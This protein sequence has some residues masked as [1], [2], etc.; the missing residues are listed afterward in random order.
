MDNQ[1]AKEQRRYLFSMFLEASKYHRKLFYFSA[2]LAGSA[3]L[4]MDIAIP[5]VVAHI[6]SDIAQ[7]QVIDSAGP[8]I[9]F[10]IALGLLELFSL[11]MRRMMVYLEERFDANCRR[12]VVTNAFAKLLEQP[13]Y[14]HQSRFV[15]TTINLISKCSDCFGRTSGITIFVFVPMSVS[16]IGTCVVLATRVPWYLVALLGITIAYT[17]V[18]L[19]LLPKQMKLSADASSISSK[20]YGAMSD[21]VSNIAAVKS[22]SGEN[23][24]F[25]RVYEIGDNWLTVH[26]SFA[27][28]VLIR[29]GILSNGL[30]RALRALSIVFAV[31]AA[32]GDVNNVA[33]IYLS[34]T[35][36]L[37]YLNHLW[38]FGD[39][40][41]ELTMAYGDAAPIVPL[42]QAKPG[43]AD[44][45]NA[46]ELQRVQG[47][48]SLEK[49]SYKYPN[50]N[51][52]V[53]TDLDLKIEPG[54]RVGIVGRSGAGKSTLVKL[55]MRF[56]DPQSGV[57]KIDDIDINDVTQE[58]LRRN[59]SYVAQ[60][61][62]LFHRSIYS[63]ITYGSTE[64]SDDKIEEVLVRSHSKEFI[65]TMPKGLRSVVGERGVNLSG[66]QRQRIAIARA[67]LKNAA[68]LILDE[69]TS[70]L[71]SESEG[72]VQSAFADLMTD[73]TT[74]VIAHRLS[75]LL[76]MDRILV[77]DEG[78]IIEQGSHEDL[79]EIKGIYSDLWSQ[80]AGGFIPAS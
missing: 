41:Y 73:R 20:M 56:I 17:F 43:V 78:R 48:I 35:L 58:S 10:L 40:L 62:M 55:I 68:I 80:Q 31:F 64:I 29:D 46:V 6:L 15:G 71:D 54:E 3:A 23:I 61:P 49:V 60:E 79:L 50:S 2:F 12:A 9:P 37:A 11:L 27:R 57:I 8:Y 52:D 21:A 44:R 72:Y 76:K 51:A 34:A 33:I 42:L 75:T 32:V 70:A 13:A 67:M 45:K 7:K 77:F 26:K 66:G 30:V 39:A 65:D 16:L 47:K 63:N 69:A 5:L 25:D 24:E 19:K 28:H 22:E 38:E 53:F 14:F 18:I 36:T 74:I 1:E 4:I 59:I